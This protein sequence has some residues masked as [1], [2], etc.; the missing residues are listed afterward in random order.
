MIHQTHVIQHHQRDD[1]AQLSGKNGRR[2]CISLVVSKQFQHQGHIC[3]QTHLQYCLQQS[4][5]T[6]KSKFV[7]TKSIVNTSQNYVQTKMS[8]QNLAPIY[9]RS[10]Y[11]M[12]L[13]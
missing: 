8:D 7:R 2:L 3:I 11:L 6:H 5:P 4:T 1:L 10:F 13:A 12:P 9:F